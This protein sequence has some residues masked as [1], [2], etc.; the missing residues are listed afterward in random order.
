MAYNLAEEYHDS[1]ILLIGINTRGD[2]VARRLQA[3]LGP[4]LTKGCDSMQIVLDGGQA[5]TIA[6]ADFDG[7]VVIIVDDVIFSGRTMQQAVTYVMQNGQPDVVR[8]VALVDRGHRR[9]P[10]EPQFRG[11][12][13]PTKLGEHVHVD[14]IPESSIDRVTL[15]QNGNF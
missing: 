10:V 6:S 5:Q 8:C 3:V 13:C 15:F 11:L 14:L 7:K 1:H 12:T 2:A 4:I 9:Y